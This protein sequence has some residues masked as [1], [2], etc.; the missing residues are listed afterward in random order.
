M[1][2][3]TNDVARTLGAT[4][5]KSPPSDDRRRTGISSGSGSCTASSS[6]NGSSIDKSRSS[7]TGGLIRG[8]RACDDAALN[9]L[10]IEMVDI[11][12]DRSGIDVGGERR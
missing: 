3:E 11:E 7:R 12:R 9:S 1:S 4:D 2:E 5:L 10:S 8:E 6:S